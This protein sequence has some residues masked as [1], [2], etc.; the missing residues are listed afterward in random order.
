MHPVKV[1]LF[2][3][4]LKL[5]D[6]GLLKEAGEVENAGLR[7][8]DAYDL[9]NEQNAEPGA[10]DDDDSEDEMDKKEMRT[11]FTERAVKK[12]GGGVNRIAMSREKVEALSEQRRAVVK[13]FLG[14]ITLGRSCGRCDG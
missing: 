1:N 5:L 2:T 10:G 7:R 4:K 8:K 13:D 3:C 12:A 6:H 9:Q 14:A 11:L